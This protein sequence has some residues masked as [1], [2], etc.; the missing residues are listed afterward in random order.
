MRRKEYQST[1]EA[2]LR[3]L[4]DTVMVGQV[5]IVTP[6]GY[7]RVVPVNFAECDGSIYFHGAQEGEK[8]DYFRQGKKVTF[9][10]Y[11]EFAYIPSHWQSEQYACPATQFYK[12][13]LIK[14]AGLIVDEPQEKAAALTALM[15]K[16]QPEGIHAEISPD[17]KMYHKAVEE[18]TIFRIRPDKTSLKGNFG[19]TLS[20][21]IRKSLA[22]KL[23]ERGLGLDIEAA[24][25]IEKSI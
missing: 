9:S 18:V 21:R 4:Y 10:I 15:R 14:G 20:S 3:M 6:E 22:E 19:Q 8:Y 25:E 13:A 2:D 16:H 23:R 5:G 1:N 17:D 24:I 11:K 7:P 12:S